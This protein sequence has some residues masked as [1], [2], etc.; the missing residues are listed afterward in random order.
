M[1]ICKFCKH[2]FPSKS[3]GIHVLNCKNNPKY[4]NYEKSRNIKRK[5]KSETQNSQIKKFEVKCCTCENIFTVKENENKFPSKLKYY[6]SRRCANT[7]NG[8]KYKKKIKNGKKCKTCE[9]VFC[10]LIK[11]EYCSKEC[12]KTFNS[13]KNKVDRCYR[14]KCSFKFSIFD[15]PKEFDLSLVEQYGFYR[16]KNSKLGPNYNG[17]SLDHIFSVAEGEKLKIDPSILSHPANCQ[18]LNHGDNVRKYKYSE[19]TLSELINK[20]EEWDNKYSSAN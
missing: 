5:N 12:L 18:L 20:I 9:V 4:G 14:T 13:K 8:A 6:C 15:F 2:E 10:N 1:A 17:I 7:H 3:M 19:I 16:P 11:T